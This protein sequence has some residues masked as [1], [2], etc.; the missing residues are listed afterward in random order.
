ML[1]SV[2]IFEYSKWTDSQASLDMYM[3]VNN[4]R[5]LTG[6]LP[7][8]LC[9]MTVPSTTK[10]EATVFIVVFVNV[11]GARDGNNNCDVANLLV[12]GGK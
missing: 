11:C 2:R 5:N 7:A 3:L 12:C 6:T 8:S 1:Y 10:T 4:R 9:I